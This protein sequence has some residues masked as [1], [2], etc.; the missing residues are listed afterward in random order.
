MNA[1]E[2]SHSQSPVPA[3][4]SPEWS[5]RVTKLISR[6]RPDDFDEL[7]RLMGVDEIPV[8]SGSASRWG[9]F[10]RQMW[11]FFPVLIAI[12]AGVFLLAFEP[13]TSI[14]GRQ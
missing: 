3:R 8:E 12:A 10:Q 14:L 11:T 7:C 6:N 9:A 13:G 4:G 1:D 2:H 5:A